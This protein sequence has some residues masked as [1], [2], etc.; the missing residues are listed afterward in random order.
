M[1]LVTTRNMIWLAMASV[2]TIGVVVLVVNWLRC[3]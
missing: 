2:W 3:H 1:T